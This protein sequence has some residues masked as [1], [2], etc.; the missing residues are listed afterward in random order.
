MSSLCGTEYP[1]FLER[2][3]EDCDML[4]A[5]RKLSDSGQGVYG[6]Y[7]QLTFE[8]EGREYKKRYATIEGARGLQVDVVSE[9]SADKSVEK[10]LD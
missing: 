2:Q 8:W 5:G 4:P 9:I 3:R 6:D 7:G 1:F 10:V